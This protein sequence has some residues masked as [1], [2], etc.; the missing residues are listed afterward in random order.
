MDQLDSYLAVL[1][2]L[3]AKILLYSAIMFTFAVMSLMLGISVVFHLYII[4]D[5]AV[6][7]ICMVM[8]L[9]AIGKSDMLILR[10]ACLILLRLLLPF[11]ISLNISD[12]KLLRCGHAPWHMCQGAH[13]PA[14]APA[15]I[16]VV[17]R[18]LSDYEK[19]KIPPQSKFLTKFFVVW[20]PR[21]FIIAFD[22]I[23]PLLFWELF[24]QFFFP[25]QYGVILSKSI[26]W[27][28]WVV[29]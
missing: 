2:S 11:E 21:E 13:P 3:L 20:A 8:D 23:F 17:F 15:E 10:M 19:S 27:V 4:A 6:N 28:K 22:R 9:N 29:N 18:E 24:P 5:R 1:P 16:W 12:Q 14:T 26:F 25:F 7:R